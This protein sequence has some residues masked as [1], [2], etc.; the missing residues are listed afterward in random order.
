MHTALDSRC[1][2]N[3]LSYNSFP[4]MVRRLLM[5]VFDVSARGHE[6]AITPQKLRPS[7]RPARARG[8]ALR[9]EKVSVD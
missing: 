8:R 1:D 5:S 3:S 9:E 6:Q 2:P 7:T 4:P